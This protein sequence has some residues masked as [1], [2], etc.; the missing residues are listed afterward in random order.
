MKE[1]TLKSNEE[2][3]AEVVSAVPL[4]GNLGEK[5]SRELSRW[6]GKS[7]AI[8]F[9]VD[10][11]ILGGIIIRLGDKVIDQSIRRQLEDLRDRLVREE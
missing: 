9:S 4:N 10:Q 5:L 11:S 2:I 3:V 6:L 7:V 1:S 8:Q